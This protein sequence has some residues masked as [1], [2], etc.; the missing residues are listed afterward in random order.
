MLMVTIRRQLS[1][2][3]FGSQSKSVQTQTVTL[4][5]VI[6]ER[7]TKNGESFAEFFRKINLIFSGYNCMEVDSKTFLVKTFMGKIF[8]F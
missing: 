5:N 8:I 2:I 1:R 3:F 4:L 6:T 7:F